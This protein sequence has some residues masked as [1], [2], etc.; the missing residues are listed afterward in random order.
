MR[1]M[2]MSSTHMVFIG[3]PGAGKS[4]LAPLLAQRLGLAFYDCDT[5]I[6]EETGLTPKALIE[7][8]GEAAFREQEYRTLQRLLANPRAVIATGGGCVV[9]DATREA[10][11]HQHVIYLKAKV[12]TL[13]DR[14]LKSHDRAFFD[15][16]QPER[17]PPCLEKTIAD[18][19]P[20][21]QALARE[22]W[23]VDNMQPESL[24]A[25]WSERHHEVA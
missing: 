2:H 8:Q 13:C 5:A 19:E 20:L 14:L 21:Y 17:L 18:R 25:A 23:C 16:A 9:F 15:K 12:E 22:T 11:K 7:T 4:T 6:T 10:L 1:R 24:I 3:M